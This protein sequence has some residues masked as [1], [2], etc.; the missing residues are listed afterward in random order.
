[1]IKFYV[2]ALKNTIGVNIYETKRYVR[3][4]VKYRKYVLK[5]DMLV[6]HLG[7]ARYKDSEFYFN[8]VILEL[9]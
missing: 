5:I 8:D 1:M 4:G 9:E 7:L 3:D 2:Q 6:Y